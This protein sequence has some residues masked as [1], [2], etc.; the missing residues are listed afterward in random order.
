[1]GGRGGV[2]EREVLDEAKNGGLIGLGDEGEWG[3]LKR[4]EKLFNFA[5]CEGAD[6][7]ARGKFVINN[8]LEMR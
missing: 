3:C 4:A 1:M 6:V 5:T 8:F 2:R 7:A